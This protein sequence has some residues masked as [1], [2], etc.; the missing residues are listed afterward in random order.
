MSVLLVRVGKWVVWVSVVMAALTAVVTLAQDAAD[1]PLLALLGRV[2]DLPGN[3][4]FTTYV[5]R[6]AIEAAYPGTRAP[7]DWA[8]FMAMNDAE[9]SDPDLLP[10]EVWWRVFMNMAVPTASSFGEGERMP[11]VMGFDYFAIDR[12]LFYGT[13][14]AAGLILQ[15]EFDEDAVRAALEAREYTASGELWCGPV[16]CDGG[17]E[18]N[19]REIE[20]SNLFGGELGRQQPVS[21]MDDVLMSSPSLEQVEGYLDAT[22]GDAES[23]A[24]D[25]RYQAAV[26]AVSELGMILQASIV[27]GEYL[28]SDASAIMMLPE[29]RAADIPQDFQTIAPYSLMLIAD[30][31]SEDEQIGVAA[32]VYGDTATAEAAVAEMTRR[33]KTLNSLRTAQPYADLLEDRYATVKTQ[34]VE[35][36]GLAVA[37]VLLTTPEA[38]V[39]QIV[40]FNPFT[41]PDD[42]PPVTAPG[43]LY[44]LLLSMVQ[45]R[46]DLWYSTVPREVM[47][48]L[49]DG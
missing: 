23:L 48:E 20:R 1:S 29:Q 14:P 41:D 30:V 19:L 18:T 37:L 47:E 8:E 32:F 7:A 25:P 11:E 43:L 3:R 12:E 16:G 10:V 26:G 27:D 6:A 21:I 31:A 45:A 15:G 40:Q 46:D 35:R 39:E 22:N 33:L 24:D 9:G 5:D 2:P 36:D 38:T 4:A 49:A 34:V 42:L 28:L 44:R 13:P 17:T